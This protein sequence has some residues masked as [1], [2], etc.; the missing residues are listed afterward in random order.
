[1]DKNVSDMCRLVTGFGGWQIGDIQVADGPH[2]IRAQKDGAKIND[3]YEA[4]CFPTASSVACSW[5]RQ[6]IQEIAKGIA[7]E[8]KKLGV[9]VVLGPGINIKRSPMCGRNFEYYSEDPFLT[10][11]IASEYVSSMQENGVGACIKHFAGNSQETHR[12]TQNSMIDERAL[13]EIYLAAFEKVIKKS[14]PAAV[15]ASYN[16][17]NG[18]PACENPVL[19][20]GIL[21]KQWEYNGV[22]ISD[23]GACV[24][25]AASISAGMDVEMPQSDES[26]TEELIE[27]LKHGEISEEKVKE[28]IIRIERLNDTYRQNII[29]DS[30]E[31]RVSRRTR[32]LNHNLAQKAE[33]ESAVLLKNE[34]YLPLSEAKEI[35]IIGNMASEPRIQGGGSS[36]INTGKVDSFIEQFEKYGVRVHFATG[37]KNATYKRNKKLENEAVNLV[38]NYKNAHIPVLFFGGLTDIAEGEGYDRDSFELPDNQSVLLQKLLDVTGEIAF[39]SVSGSPYDMEL[40]SR[41]KALLQLYLGGEAVAEACVRIILGLVNPSG[42]LAETIPFK[43]IDAPCYGSFGKQADQKYHLDD[44]EYRE[45]IFVGYRYYDSFD[46][47]VRYCF[48]HGLSYTSFSYS[49]LEIESG[50]DNEYK[51]T[52]YLENTGRIAGS[53]ISELYIKNPD[54]KDFRAKRELRGFAKTFLKPGEKQ[55]VEIKLDSRAFSIYQNSD[56]HI[57]SGTYEVQIGA[58]LQDIRL[59]KNIE[60][61]GEHIKC[62]LNSETFVPLSDKDFDMV[63]NYPRTCFSFPRPGEFTTRNSLIQLKKY[64]WKARLLLCIGKLYI[65]FRYFPKSSKDP[66]VRMMLDGFTEGNVDSI[67]NQN[68]R[69]IKHKTIINMI[70]SANKKAE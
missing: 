61:S 68:K 59:T 56:F 70:N 13:H 41:C 52:F 4:T 48:G 34:N 66:E 2:G 20:T 35:I 65:R 63:Y 27:A 30:E 23:W 64:S 51:I 6:L 36:H 9:S 47:P 29:E 18:V 53:E 1:M 3:S 44:V 7:D 50:K 31:K 32:R 62:P 38:K 15:M 69:L 28:S 37:Y 22:V 17:I 45:S 43:E 40:P 46:I 60:V 24:N 10:G 8:A 54:S 25:L 5:N 26:H 55:K 67:C 16:Y 19:L 57:I 42:K 21:R 12:M 49:D 39:V 14:K 33:E 11:E 58:S